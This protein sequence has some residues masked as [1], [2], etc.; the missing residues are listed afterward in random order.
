[1]ESQRFWTCSFTL[2]GWCEDGKTCGNEIKGLVLWKSYIFALL[3][4]Y[5]IHVS[6]EIESTTNKPNCPGFEANKIETIY[7]FLLRNRWY[8]CEALSKLW[9]LI[10]WRSNINYIQVIQSFNAKCKHRFDQTRVCHIASIHRHWNGQICILP[11]KKHATAETL[12]PLNS[13]HVWWYSSFSG[14]P[15]R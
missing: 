15:S 3:L 1:M 5:I 9:F 7:S 12:F 10:H 4:F 14:K 6:T 11:I 13:F 8:P 2:T